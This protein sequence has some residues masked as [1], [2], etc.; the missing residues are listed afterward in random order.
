MAFLCKRNILHIVGLDRVNLK[1][2]ISK[3]KF[4]KVNLEKWI[5][6]NKFPKVKKCEKSYIELDMIIFNW[7]QWCFTLE[8]KSTLKS[9]KSLRWWLVLSPSPCH[10]SFIKHE[11]VQTI[12]KVFV[13]TLTCSIVHWPEADFNQWW[14]I[15]YRFPAFWLVD[16]QQFWALIGWC[17]NQDHLKLWLLESISFLTVTLLNMEICPE[18]NTSRSIFTARKV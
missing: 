4:S 5:P 17:W 8:Y 12:R 10:V 11:H 7:F 1:K 16:Y 9:L 18:I 13:E 6:K 2:W 14:A 15:L 3:S